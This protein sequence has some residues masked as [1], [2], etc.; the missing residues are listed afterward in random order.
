MK[1]PTPDSVALEYNERLT[2]LIRKTIS[3]AGGSIDFARFMDLALYTPELGYYSSGAHKLGKHGDFITAPEISPL[4]AKCI[5][6][7]CRDILTEL[8]SGDILEF[9]AGSGVFAKDL[10]LALEK[11]DCLPT[12]YFILEVSAELRDRQKKQIASACPHLFDRVEWLDRLPK[13][14]KGI[15]FANEVLDAFPV[16]RFRIEKDGIKERAVT[17]KNDRFEWCSVE[18]SPALL[19]RVNALTQNFELREG[20][21]SEINL[22][23]PAWIRS[24]A[25]V[26][27]QGVVL[28]I[29]YGYGEAEYYHPDRSEGSLQCYYQHH[30]H[31]D[32]LILV[33]LQDITAHV[34]FT[35]VAES[36]CHAG[37]ELAGF[38][39]QASFLLA[40]GL[41]EVAEK[42]GLSAKEHFEETQAIK[43][44]TMPSAM[45]EAVKVI[46]FRKNLDLPLIGFCL[47]DRQRTL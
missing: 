46:G 20:Y 18:P 13:E 41:L 36:A 14:L 44:L 24:I 39:T 33:G 31:D 1:L 19:D 16:R 10:L 7:Q 5:A 12:H 25:D 8:K 37:L 11:L 47:S 2:Q 35:A 30:R 45:G 34:D 38:T 43:K 22:I 3:A 28:L 27:T 26:L 29:D 21:E 42:T 4:F 15:I 6:R 32:P 40:C 23:L 9:G 17:F